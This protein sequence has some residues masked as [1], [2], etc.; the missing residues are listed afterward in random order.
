M[1]IARFEQ[2]VRRSRFRLEMLETVPIRKL[3]PLHRKLTRE[4]TTAIV[5][6]KLAR[7]A[8]AI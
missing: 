5:R 1:T 6:A 4:F 7:D 2:L 3:R 8:Q